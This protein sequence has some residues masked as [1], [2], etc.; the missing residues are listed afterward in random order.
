MIPSS[1]SP[2]SEPAPMPAIRASDDDRAAVVRL[3]QDG[4]ARGTLTL[5]ECDDRVAAAYGAR[6]REELPLLTADL[7]PA[8]ASA[9]TPPGWQALLTLLLLQMRTSLSALP[10]GGI[11]LSPRGRVAL[12]AIIVVAA[13]LLGASG[14]EGLLDVVD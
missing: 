7:P 12:P 6:F 8:P 13:V 9:P 3:L 2:G 10:G 1:H 14:V 11:A 5:A 4:V